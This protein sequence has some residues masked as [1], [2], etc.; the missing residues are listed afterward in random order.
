MP[1]ETLV[2][3]IGSGCLFSDRQTLTVNEDLLEQRVGEMA[4]LLGEGDRSL[5]LVTSGA[6]SL[7]RK[8]QGISYNTTLTDEEKQA[9]STVGQ[10][11]LHNLYA[12]Q[13]ARHGITTGQLLYNHKYLK[14]PENL[15]RL[16]TMMQNENVVM[17]CNE[18]DALFKEEVHLNNDWPAA[19]LASTVEADVLLM[20][21]HETAGLQDNEGNVLPYISRIGDEHYRMCRADEMNGSAGGMPVKLR[22]AELAISSCWIDKEGK[23][24]L[25]GEGYLRTKRQVPTIM[26]DIRSPL[27]CL[28]Y[29]THSIERTLFGDATICKNYAG[30]T[31]TDNIVDTLR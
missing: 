2:I 3:K 14:R 16:H 10:P 11:D 21:M 17:I 6:V 7:G 5:F 4:M 31:R 1:H 20:L 29:G 27:S 28:L 15:T 24:E 30:N 12:A 18:N 23:P 9:L 8:R 19:I 26:G 25:D 13:F 22:A